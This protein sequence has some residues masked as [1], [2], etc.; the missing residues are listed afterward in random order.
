MID[1]VLSSDGIHGEIPGTGPG[2]YN[3]GSLTE[4][5]QATTGVGCIVL[6]GFL[7]MRLYVR[8]HL[9]KSWLVDDCKPSNP[10]VRVL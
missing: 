2:M 3:I 5:V 1:P 6:S 7:A 8:L 9:Q 10:I 4:R